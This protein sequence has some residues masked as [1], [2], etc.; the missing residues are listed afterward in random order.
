LEEPACARPFDLE[1]AHVRDVEG[2]GV[3]TH[4]AV[5]RNDPGVL[6]RH[7]PAREGHHPRPEG[8]M[9]IV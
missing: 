4:R 3:L 5:F 2:A 7:L 8:D 1:L 6:H 9:A